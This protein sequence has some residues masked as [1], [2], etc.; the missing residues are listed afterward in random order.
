MAGGELMIF[1]SRQINNDPQPWACHT[2]LGRWA[3]QCDH[4]GSIHS[5]RPEFDVTR[6]PEPWIIDTGYL[7]IRSAFEPREDDP[8]VVYAEWSPR[9]DQFDTPVNLILVEFR[10]SQHSAQW[11]LATLAHEPE[12]YRWTPAQIDHARRVLTRLAAVTL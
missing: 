2:H 1:K 5:P 12:S 8:L 7:V 9:R 4:A 11:W 3:G 6:D 10:A